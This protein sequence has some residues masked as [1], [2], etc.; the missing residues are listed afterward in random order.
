MSPSAAQAL[1]GLEAISSLLLVLSAAF[2]ASVGLTPAIRDRA[3]GRG[4]LDRPDG[5][6]KTHADAVPRLGGLAVY[7]AFLLA[8]LAA[9]TLLPP[10]VWLGASGIDAALHVLLAGGAV[11][12]IGLVDDV[13]G[14]SPAAKVLVQL[15][16]AFYLYTAGFQVQMINTPGGGQVTLG[17]LSLPVTLLW[18]V[19]LSNAFN[20]IDGLDGLAAGVG[21]FALSVV[22]TFALLNERWEI[23]ILAVAL[24]GALL[25]FLRY[26]FS[27]AS[28]FLGDS[29]SLFVGFALAAL[30]IRGSMKSSTAVAVITPL[31]ALGFPIVDTALT[32]VRRVL[33]GRSILEADADHIHHRMMRRGL[34]PQRAVVILYGVTALF[35]AMALL[36]MTGQA[37]AVGLAVGGFT[38]V[39]WLGIRQLGYRE[40]EQL[41]GLFRLT[42][43]GGAQRA[44]VRLR[45]RLEA[46]AGLGSVWEGLAEAAVDVG[47]DAIALRL[48][49]AG[50]GPAG[51]WSWRG[52]RADDARPAWTWTLP[53]VHDGHALGELTL[54]RTLDERRLALAPGEI[55]RLA[56]DVAET[57][58][59]ILHAAA[60]VTSAA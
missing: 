58:A 25:G 26:N 31:L 52:P 12:L 38:L 22:F 45:G 43:R 50:A 46:A 17:W 33:R 44:L 37:Q 35:G 5:R 16:A 48:G 53:L 59:R 47:L 49:D 21:L 2:L 39:T 13:R 19:G 51:S 34:T 60:G 9:V 40:L 57:V 41:P 56:A 27:P 20:L 11:M 24:A 32:L 1:S 8:F 29:G 7:L 55:E 36:S 42:R 15:A 28:V 54:T 23:A 3:R 6:R 4:W 14:T 30:S 18:V 10:S